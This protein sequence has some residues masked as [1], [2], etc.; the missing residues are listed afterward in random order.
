MK[1][2][3]PFARFFADAT[4]TLGEATFAETLSIGVKDWIGAD[5]ISLI[6]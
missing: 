1:S 4:A 6:R 2:L 5:D 3:L